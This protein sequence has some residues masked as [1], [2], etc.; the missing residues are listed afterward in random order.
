MYWVYHTHF[1]SLPMSKIGQLGKTTHCRDVLF[2][3]NLPAVF[4]VLPSSYMSICPKN[5]NLCPL[6]YYALLCFLRKLLNHIKHLVF[7][8]M[9]FILSLIYFSELYLIISTY[10]EILSIKFHDFTWEFNINVRQNMKQMRFSASLFS[11]VI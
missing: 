10:N 4:L 5:V 7:I 8:L 1:S 3:K 9:K 6:K 2:Y 11:D